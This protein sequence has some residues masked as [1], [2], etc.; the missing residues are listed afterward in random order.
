MCRLYGLRSKA[1]LGVHEHLV[2]EANSLKAQSHEHKDGWGIAHYQKARVPRV[3]HGLQPAHADPD[4]ESASS[5]VSSRAVVA[6]L[7]L[8]SVGSVTERNAHPFTYGA[9]T[10]AHNGTLLDFDDHRK[11]IEERISPRF[12]AL[13]KGDTDSERCFYLF[14]S[15]LTDLGAIHGHPGAAKVAKA[16]ALVTGELAQL[17]HRAGAEKP[18]SMN[19]L[20]T[21]GDVMVATRTRKSLFYSAAGAPTPGQ[22]VDA[23][24]IASEA[25]SKDGPWHEIPE[26]TAV[27]VEG[28]L[29][30]RRWTLDEL[31]AA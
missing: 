3:H 26:S 19:F 27:G 1:P 4:F 30:F 13:L 2:G 15:R 11:A 14:L 8:A 16:L 29:V 23:L 6:H 28:D 24:V 7:R 12:R 21:N 5:T 17:T 9:W 25:L 20:A 18:S 31:R 10:F 22:K